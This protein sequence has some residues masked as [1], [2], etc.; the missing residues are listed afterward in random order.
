MI[1]VRHLS[2]Q[3]LSNKRFSYPSALLF[4]LQVDVS[5]PEASTK[6]LVAE[7]AITG[8]AQ[9]ARVLCPVPEVTGKA[10]MAVVSRLDPWG[11]MIEGAVLPCMHHS[12]GGQQAPVAINIV[13]GLTVCLSADHVLQ[14]FTCYAA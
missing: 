4:Y 12:A 5:P 1:S 6:G 9:G 3:Y 13:G 7:L 8:Q 11:N 10:Q 14:L 2:T